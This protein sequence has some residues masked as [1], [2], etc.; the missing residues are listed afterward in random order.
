MPSY[1]NTIC[2]HSPIEASAAI[3]RRCDQLARR[4]TGTPTHESSAAAIPNRMADERHGAPAAQCDLGEWKR[5]GE[6]DIGGE[7]RNHRL[8]AG[9]H[10]CNDDFPLVC[11]NL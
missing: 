2:V 9:A 10:R 3:R 7:Q 8:T 11:A 6:E 5:P 4:S 1:T